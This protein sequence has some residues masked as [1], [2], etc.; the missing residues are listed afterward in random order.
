[1]GNRLYVGQKLRTLTGETVVI[2]GLNTSM[3]CVEYKGKRIWRDQTIIG[4]KL[5]IIEH[6]SNVHTPLNTVGG[7]EG[8]SQKESALSCNDCMLMRRED[9]FGAKKICKFFQHAVNVSREEID[10]WPTIGDATRYR[11]TSKKRNLR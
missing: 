9:C 5:F 8:S 3:I 11:M 1:M 6:E 7:T 2:K 4:N 10:S